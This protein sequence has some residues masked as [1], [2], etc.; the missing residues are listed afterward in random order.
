MPR[1]FF[2]GFI[3]CRF[4][5]KATASS[6]INITAASGSLVNIIG[7]SGLL[8]STDI[9]NELRNTVHKA[10]SNINTGIA[11][12]KNLLFPSSLGINPKRKPETNAVKVNPG[13]NGPE[14]K[15][16]APIKSASAPHIP[17]HA[18]PLIIEQTRIGKK[19]TPML[20]FHTL[21]DKNRLAITAST[22]RMAVSTIFI[23]K[24]LFFKIKNLL[25]RTKTMEKEA[26]L[27]LNRKRQRDA[28]FKSQ[29]KCSFVC[30]TTPRPDSTE[31][32][33]ALT[34]KNLL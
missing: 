14:G 26:N 28:V 5:I 8:Y 11:A 9:H 4:M 15:S 13:K 29:S 33:T 3:K 22:Q 25:P 30:R 6:I 19:E 32:K 34:L 27:S 2:I 10:P 12:I 18:R 7:K 17:P 20:K 24:D 1:S 23:R 21:K 31:A 16:M